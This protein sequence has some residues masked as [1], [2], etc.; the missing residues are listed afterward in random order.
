MK[1]R[2]ELDY[3]ARWI[4]KPAREDDEGEKEKFKMRVSGIGADAKPMQVVRRLERD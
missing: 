3:V 4:N 1:K 2:K